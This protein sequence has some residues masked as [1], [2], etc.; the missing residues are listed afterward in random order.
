MRVCVCMCVRKHEDYSVVCIHMLINKSAR[1]RDGNSD[2]GFFS[3]EL[4]EINRT[5]VV[6]HRAWFD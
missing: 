1:V 6:T 2:R 5:P 4:S 3:R